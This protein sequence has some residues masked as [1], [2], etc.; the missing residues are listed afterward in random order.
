MKEIS[1]SLPEELIEAM[2]AIAKKQG[3]PLND[4]FQEFLKSYTEKAK[5]QPE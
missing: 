2:R 1:L 3:K 4:L 5:N